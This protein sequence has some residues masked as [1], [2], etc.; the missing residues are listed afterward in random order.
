MKKIKLYFVFSSIFIGILNSSFA[1]TKY[2]LT[3][4]NCAE[5]N[6]GMINNGIDSAFM[7]I[8]D[9]E[10]NQKIEYKKDRFPGEYYFS[11][12]KSDVRIEIENIF[13]QKT[14]TILKLNKKNTEYQICEDKF[15]DYELKTSVEKS[16]EIKKK[17]TLLYSSMGCFHWDKESI[18]LTYKKEKVYATYKVNKKKKQKI[19]LTQEKMNSLIL[20]EKKL[21]L[22][23]RPKGGCTTSDIYNISGVEK[24]KIDDSSCLWN[25]YSNLK[26]KLGFE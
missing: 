7:T 8:Y 14:D 20:F 6:I 5:N 22:M 10:S 2:K 26:E 18:E 9:N 21:K 19:I 12:K 15:Q 16:F 1:Q 11:T 24:Y 4:Y 25:G 23:D 13:K 3:F 17:W